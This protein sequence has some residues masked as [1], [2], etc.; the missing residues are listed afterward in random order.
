MHLLDNFH[1]AMSSLKANKMRSFLTMLGIIIGVAAVIAILTVGNSINANVSDMM[2]GMGANDI[3]VS[4]TERSSDEEL[5]EKEIEDL[6]VDGLKFGSSTSGKK[7]SDGDYITTDMLRE[8]CR[9]FPDEDS[10]IRKMRFACL[11][12]AAEMVNICQVN[13]CNDPFSIFRKLGNG[14]GTALIGI[15]L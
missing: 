13:I 1:L 15:F 8:L 9:R 10:A 4:V 5:S 6:P 11:A 7:K 2:Q 14:F 12:P 3:F